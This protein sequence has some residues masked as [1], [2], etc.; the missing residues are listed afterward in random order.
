[1]GV[2]L[3]VWIPRS[4]DYVCN[5]QYISSMTPPGSDMSQDEKNLI[6]MDDPRTKF[7]EFLNQEGNKRIFFSGRFGVGK[8][9]FLQRFFEDRES[10]YDVYHIYPV[11]YQI[12]SNENIVKLFK[13]DIFV[14]LLQKYPQAFDTPKKGR[15]RY[16][17]DFVQYHICKVARKTLGEARISFEAIGIPVDVRI[18][19]VKVFSDIVQNFRL[20]RE[21]ISKEF[22]VK[23]KEEFSTATDQIIL[24]L[25]YKIKELKGERESVFILDDFDRIDPDHI[26]RI[27]NILSAHMEGD[28]DNKFGFDHI[29]VVGDINNL[30]SIF[31]HK[32]GK[33]TEFQGYFD[34]FFTIKPYEFNNDDAIADQI[35]SL[36]QMIQFEDKRLKIE[37]AEHEGLIKVL[38]Q[39]VLGDALS[40]KYF[41]L[42]QRGRLIKHSFSELNYPN[43]Y[44][45]DE[46][47]QYI[48][49]GIRLLV[50]L[51]GG[52]EH[53]LK[54]LIKMRDG[55]LVN[56]DSFR[57]GAKGGYIISLANIM[58]ERMMT[59]MER[60]KIGH[61]AEKKDIGWLGQYIVFGNP[62]LHPEREEFYVLFFYDVLIEYV[63]RHID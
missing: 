11:R 44:P 26:F 40:E 52:K 5:P 53:L 38:L 42:R 51:Y 35:P 57:H 33:D 36:L 20:D 23:A 45:P 58:L 43:E 14:K 22:M 41:N 63:K 16:C 3:R 10:D 54:I 24:L 18:N 46:K 56:R 59:E 1:M 28:E 37:M 47:I 55:P 27:L 25:S 7:E 8:T 48:N 2:A 49:I 6:P 62:H 13:Y 17:W 19:A 12:S 32:Y 21:G 39:I 61:P 50:A 34:K 60:R 29:I 4:R 9:F 15:I 31:H 30:E